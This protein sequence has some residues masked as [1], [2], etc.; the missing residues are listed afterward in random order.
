MLMREAKLMGTVLAGVVAAVAALLS[1]HIWLSPGSAASRVVEVV[2]TS[3]PYLAIGLGLGYAG[4]AQ[5]RRSGKRTYLFL[6]AIALLGCCALPVVWKDGDLR[7]QVSRLMGFLAALIYPSFPGSPYRLGLTLFW[8]FGLLLALVASPAAG[9]AAYAVVLF[10]L[11]L[12]T[13]AVSWDKR[14][15]ARPVPDCDV[16]KASM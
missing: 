5:A 11:G 10:V 3:G 12:A 13:W 6:A 16:P 4:W 15:R 2:I 1:V 9:V 7:T 8:L 14:G